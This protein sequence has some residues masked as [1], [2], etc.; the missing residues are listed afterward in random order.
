M[1]RAT[2]DELEAAFKKAREL[3]D[4]S[5]YGHYFTDDICHQFSMEIAEA[6]LAIRLAR[7][8]GGDDAA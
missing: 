6:V 7:T 5:G 1:N 2:Y 4:R 3:A 8:S